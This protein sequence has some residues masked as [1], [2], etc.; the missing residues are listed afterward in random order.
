MS[1][2]SKIDTHEIVSIYPID[3]DV[4]EQ[5]LTEQ[6]E[7]SFNWS[8]RDGWPVGVIMSY[9][10]RDGKFWLTAGMHRHRIEA[11][12]RDPRVSLVI[13]SVGTSLGG[14]K[15]ITVKGRAEVHE[16]RATKEWFYAGFHVQYPGLDAPLRIVVSVT[17]EKWITFDGA[18]MKAH[19][20]GE[21]DPARM[22]PRLF[23][24]ATRLPKI[25]ASRGDE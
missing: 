5:L 24:D 25:V 20:R 6:R 22:G 19:E 15:S 11:I 2:P 21:L 12:R 17:P 9:S 16:D 4:Q 18:K 1:E 14:G 7:C 3:P 10:W 23:S 13:T 8:T